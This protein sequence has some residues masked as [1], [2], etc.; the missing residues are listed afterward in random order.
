MEEKGLERAI[1]YR[2]PADVY[3]F[4]FKY[5]EIE[6]RVVLCIGKS[7][8]HIFDTCCAYLWTVEFNHKNWQHRNIGFLFSAFKTLVAKRLLE[9]P[10]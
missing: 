3:C 6:Q 1:L 4:M 8:E 10:R 2:L 9:G 7:Q 5:W